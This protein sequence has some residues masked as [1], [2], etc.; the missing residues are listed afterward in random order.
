MNQVKTLRTMLEPLIN[1]LEKDVEELRLKI[2]NNPDV[3]KNITEELNRM[4]ERLFFLKVQW[5]DSE[6]K[7]ILD[8]PI[9]EQGSVEYYRRSLVKNKED[10]DIFTI[11]CTE[12]VLKDD[13]LKPN[14]KIKILN[15][16]M[17]VYK[18]LKSE[19]A[20]SFG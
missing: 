1:D 7:G 11:Q 10:I 6:K 9:Y 8:E 17:K 12:D 16:L 4:K 3:P 15:N 2:N 13:N 5:V 20:N 18:E 19:L 14:Q